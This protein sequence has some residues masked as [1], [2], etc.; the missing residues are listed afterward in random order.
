MDEEQKLPK[1]IEANAMF[2]SEIGSFTH[3]HAPLEIKKW[4]E[5]SNSVKTKIRNSLS[6]NFEF[7]WTNSEL[8]KYVEEKMAKTF[9]SWRN[10][11]YGHFKKHAHDL[12]YAQAHP[13][14][15]KLWGE[16]SI[17][18][19]EWLCDELYTNEAY[20]KRCKINADNRNMKEYNQCGGSRPYP[21]YMEAQLKLKFH[22][23]RRRLT[24]APPFSGDGEWRRV[25]PTS[26]Y[27]LLGFTQF[28][29]TKQLS[30]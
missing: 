16:R 3:K 1:T 20:V 6:T 27:V 23:D 2:A 10:K 22:D 12:E 18:E 17:N 29:D 9:R 25:R 21:K 5:V 4:K 19:W 26:E 28:V 15:E 14:E 8:R 30:C 7:K 24:T 13:P 11:L